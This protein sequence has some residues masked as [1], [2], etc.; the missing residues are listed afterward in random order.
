MK[1]QAH[2]LYITSKYKNMKNITHNNTNAIFNSFLPKQMFIRYVPKNPL[3][4][5]LF[6]QDY[7]P[8]FHTHLVSLCN[9]MYH[10]RIRKCVS[11]RK[12]DIHC[13]S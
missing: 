6:S 4:N 9:T 1:G 13:M 5:P 2:K 12:I 7:D 3:F 10:Q 11:G 8:K